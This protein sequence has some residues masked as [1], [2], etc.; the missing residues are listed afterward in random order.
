M[1]ALFALSALIIAACQAAPAHPYPDE[2]R[3]AF[4]AMCRM[5]EEPCDCAW[6]KITRA[7]THAEYQQALDTME[8]KGV[9][10]PRVVQASLQCRP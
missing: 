4:F 5:G 8:A 6:T 9:M 7:M 1:R 3:E 10:D 2:A